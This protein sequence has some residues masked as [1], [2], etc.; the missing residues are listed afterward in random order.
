MG[1]EGVGGVRGVA[2]GMSVAIVT[3]PERVRGGEQWPVV[4]QLTVDV[5]DNGQALHDLDCATGGRETESR[6]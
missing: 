2:G 6:E 5:A 4:R 3:G 1:S